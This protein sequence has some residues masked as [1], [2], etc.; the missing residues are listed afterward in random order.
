MSKYSLQ[1]AASEK[2]SQAME[3]IEEGRQYL[4]KQGL[5]QWQGPY[6]ERE[7]IQTDILKGRGYF[8]SDGMALLAYLCID[9]QGEP[10]YEK[11]E[12]QWN[13]T[14]PYA[15][16][17]RLAISAASR[18]KGLS[19]E[20]FQLAENLCWEKG[21]PYIRIDTHR[22]NEPM[23]HAIQK[24]GFQYCGI[25]WCPEGERLAFDKILTRK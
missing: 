22:N 10:D 2:I 13:C 1:K 24:N 19:G 9:F 6:P 17:H 23:K 21:I 8:V 12:G 11:I 20:V 16:I 4:K 3:L 18:G 5:D 14:S 15:V 25:I 7:D